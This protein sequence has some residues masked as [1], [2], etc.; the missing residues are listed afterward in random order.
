[1]KQIKDLQIGDKVYLLYDDFTCVIAEL[2]NLN[3]VDNFEFKGIE[4]IFTEINCK[5]DFSFLYNDFGVYKNYEYFYPDEID[6]CIVYLTKENVIQHI[7][8]SIDTGNA[9][10]QELLN[11]N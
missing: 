11:I 7:K 5:W 4:L 6:K 2:T 10:I 1:M 8:N 3:K 9:T